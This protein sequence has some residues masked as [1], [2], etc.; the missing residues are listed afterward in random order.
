MRINFKIIV[1][2]LT[3]LFIV[4]A[5]NPPNIEW[6]QI[7]TKHFRIMFP[8]ELKKNAQQVA[9]TLEHKYAA[10]SNS[11]NSNPDP[12]DIYLYNRQVFSNGYFTLAPRHSVF[13]N[14][15][16][17]NHNMLGCANWY[18]ILSI[19]EFRHCNQ[20]T[21]LNQNTTRLLSWLYGDYGE[22]VPLVFT[23]YWFFEGDAVFTETVLTNHGR[24]RVP[25]F[26]MHFRSLLLEDIDFSYQNAK[27]LSYKDYY[28]GPYT[29]GYLMVAN[30]RKNFAAEAVNKTISRSSWLPFFPYSFSNSLKK[31]T[32]YNS[33]QRFRR[34]M[35]DLD[36][37]WEARQEKRNILQPSH[38]YTG[39]KKSWTNYHHPYPLNNG[40]VLAV[41]SGLVDAGSVV[42][43]K[44]KREKPLFKI[45]AN[46]YQ[47]DGKYIHSNGQQ[48][49]WSS[50]RN[51]IRWT[52]VGYS[53]IW[54][55][56]LKN[57]KSHKITHKSRFQSPAISPDGKK[58]VAVETGLHNKHR[59]VILNTYNGEII[60]KYRVFDNHVVRRPDWSPSGNRIVFAHH[61]GKNEGLAILN[62]T[63]KKIREIIK[64]SPENLGEPT[65][66]DEHNIVYQ[67]SYSGVDNIYFLNLNNNKNY[68]ISSVK[69][70]AFH[71]VYD[72]HCKRILFSNYTING[73]EIA[74]LDRNLW[75]NL[76]K[77]NLNP[78][79]TAYFKPVLQQ[80]QNPDR[81]TMHQ[82]NKKYSL[83]PFNPYKN[84]FNIHSWGVY[85]DNLNLVGKIISDNHLHTLHTEAGFGYNSNEKRPALFLRTSFRRFFPV[86]NFEANYS[87]RHISGLTDYDW[88]ENR[89][90]S[91]ISLPLNLSGRVYSTK[92]EI[93]ADLEYLDINNVYDGE[94]PD[95]KLTPLSYHLRFR[96]S[97]QQ[98]PRDFAP[99]FGQFFQITL[100]QTPFDKY[101]NEYLALKSELFF[102]GL[103]AHHSIQLKINY[104]ARIIKS[105]IFPSQHY[106]T[107]GYDYQI[108]NKIVRMTFDY[109][110]PLIYPDF[111]FF[112]LLNIKRVRNGFFYDHG[113]GYEIDNY[114]NYRSFGIELVFDYNLFNLRYEISTALE[115]ARCLDAPHKNNNVFTIKL[116]GLRF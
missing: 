89:I 110:F 1:I 37:L 93:G 85:S 24:G 62:L 29:L 108:F 40:G 65:F 98:A 76:E 79:A 103:G 104:E 115:Y 84:L 30:I 67:S 86:F 94:I 7:T 57:K 8:G 77:N 27:L 3:S 55:Y 105:Y 41:K 112:S 73:Y 107:R 78:E 17:Q 54:L 81:F 15:P 19:H 38:V 45:D 82:E 113:L 61:N 48:I 68:K 109:K 74:G 96:R 116:L 72:H 4:R 46:S 25:Y 43:I 47:P 97:L 90:S 69:Y 87:A 36:S 26:D 101:Y 50:L 20:F 52:E 10:I 114:K 63:D 39:N 12:L 53:E 22:S 91:G 59:L 58:I 75:L 100:D 16:P 6:K 83:K 33:G 64:P 21:A 42:L 44:D 2:I 95:K 88:T 35:Q 111:N 49:V 51:H 80:E 70:G 14:T 56:N 34:T 102:P 28:P 23:P 71:P 32:G 66:I 13:Y 31:Y 9:N 18:K 92:L 60:K 5:Q 11:L 106:F 99:Q